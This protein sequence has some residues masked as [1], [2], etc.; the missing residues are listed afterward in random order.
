MTPPNSKNMTQTIDDIIT[1]LGC[2]N[3]IELL[4]RQG[5]L[6]YN[7]YERWRSG[8]QQFICELLMGSAKRINT[9]LER[10]K[11]HAVALKLTAETFQTHG[12]QGD[13]LNQPLQFCPDNSEIQTALLNTQYV[14]SESMPQLDLFFDNQGVQLANDLKLA[15]SDRH[16]ALAEEKLSQL[17]HADPNHSLCG[18]GA[19]LLKALQQ[20]PQ[21]ELK[22]PASELSYLQQT[23]SPLA[24][25]ALTDKARDFIAPFWRRLA[26]NLRPETY[27][28]Q[29][30]QL[31]PA[32]CYEQ[33]LDWPQVIHSIQQINNWQQHPPLFAS[34]SHAF[35]HNDQRI[36]SIQVLC[37]YCWLHPQADVFMPDDFN[38]IQAWNQFIDEEL[39]EKWG[40]QYFPAWLLLKEQGLSLH[41]TPLTNATPE[42]F[43]A[44]QQLLGSNNNEEEIQ[45]RQQLQ[46]AHEGVFKY[47]LQ[48]KERN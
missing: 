14:R 1:E 19:Q 2:Y 30:A 41:L 13:K 16:A 24:K 20:L 28:P 43:L 40:L 39:D 36:K 8:E 29:Q 7:D 32:Y 9:L 23:L 22:D 12:W 4:L 6:R 21:T 37:D 27:Q 46:S 11:N 45:Q 35:F 3:P 34:L 47:Y 38:C 33:I 25:D 10:A 15:L 44:L 42:A 26:N 31:H 17:E 18:Q 48:G 5:R